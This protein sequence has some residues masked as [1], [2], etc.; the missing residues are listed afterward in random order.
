MVDRVLIDKKTRPVLRTVFFI[1]LVFRFLSGFLI[2]NF[3]I[4]D[5][6]ILN[7]GFSDFKKWFLL[8][9]DYRNQKRRLS[10]L[11]LYFSFYSFLFFFFF[12]LFFAVLKCCTKNA[13]FFIF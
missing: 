7:F 1:F 13:K 12:I 9:A 11:V 8:G 5:F 4:S 3:W 2:L 10:V 6:L